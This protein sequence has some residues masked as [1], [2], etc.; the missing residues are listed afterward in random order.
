MILMTTVYADRKLYQACNHLSM[1][2]L[3]LIHVSKSGH[4]SAGMHSKEQTRILHIRDWKFK[5]YRRM[6]AVMIDP[7]Q[8]YTAS[9]R[10]FMWFAS[11]KTSYLKIPPLSYRIFLDIIRYIKFNTLHIETDI[12][13]PPFRGRHFSNIFTWVKMYELL[14]KHHWY[15]FRRPP[16]P[17]SEPTM[18]ILLM[19]ICATWP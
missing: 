13:L 12:N 2:G 10:F 16:T 9:I 11:K 6:L 3:K 1:L 14:L 15:L 4:W 17:F 8:S 5:C 18:V 7:F 19:H